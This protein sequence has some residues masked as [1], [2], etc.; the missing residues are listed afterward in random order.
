[1]KREKEGADDASLSCTTA[2]DEI[3]GGMVSHTD[4]LWSLRKSSIQV[5]SV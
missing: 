5:H 3:G 4:I 2:H 1:M